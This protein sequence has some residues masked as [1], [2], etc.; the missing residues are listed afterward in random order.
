LSD[1]RITDR[2]ALIVR[3]WLGVA[4]YHTRIQEIKET[5]HFNSL[6]RTEPASA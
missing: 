3:E 4:F 1:N 6:A 2:S 5:S